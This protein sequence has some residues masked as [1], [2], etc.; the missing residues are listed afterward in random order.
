VDRPRGTAPS[1]RP[2][3]PSQ[4]PGPGG[5]RRR[6]RGEGQPHR[7]RRLGRLAGAQIAGFETPVR[8][9]AR[10][11]AH[12]AGRLYRQL[13]ALE[14]TELHTRAPARSARN[15]APRLRAHARGLVVREPI[16][17]TRLANLGRLA[18]RLGE[19][20]V[21]ALVGHELAVAGRLLRATLEGHLAAALR[22]KT[23]AYLLGPAALPVEILTRAVRLVRDGRGF[24][25]N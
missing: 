15:R 11:D 21:G 9:Q 6:A 8:K 5:D 3:A 1:P 16:D 7:P 2:R 12:E 24:E 10:E 25:R 4:G 19:H 17:D 20:Q 22:G 13:L 23:K 18:L 14:R